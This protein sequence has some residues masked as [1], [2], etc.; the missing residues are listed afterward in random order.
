MYYEEAGQCEPIVFLHG[1]SLDHRM[2]QP[3]AVFF[4]DGF[5]VITPDALGHGQSDA[6]PTGYSRAHRVQDLADFVDNLK[7]EKFH[8]VGL[9]MG[10]A[11]AIGYAL[12]HQARL[13]S[14]CLVSTGAA[15]YSISK[16]FDRLDQV[17]RQKSVETAMA[18][19]KRWSLAWYREERQE[20]GRQIE[21]MMNGYSGAV[22]KDPM[23]GF[24]PK[25]DDLSR[26]GESKV[27]TAIFAGASDRV[28]AVLAEKLH[29]R[30]EAS[31]LAIYENTGHML[32]L[33][34]PDRYNADLK[35]FLEGVTRP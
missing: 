9:S 14:L 16:K 33:E 27:P 25:E 30:I 21:E 1:F 35:V 23:R 24:Y 6:P 34:Q 28:F 5:R 11:T 18:E 17:A 3:Q 4:R 15:G 22:W 7:I 20:L 8:L 12:E 29:R 2:W 31:Q 19:W 32:S 10:G 13:K 26:V